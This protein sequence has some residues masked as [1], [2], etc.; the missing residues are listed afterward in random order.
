MAAGGASLFRTAAAAGVPG[1]VVG[2]VVAL[3]VVVVVAVHIGVIGQRSG[4]QC[5]HGGVG[6]A[7]GGAERARRR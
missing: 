5:L 2:A 3:G 7:H 1:A 4:Q 6:R